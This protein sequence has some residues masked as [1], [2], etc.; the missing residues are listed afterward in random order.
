MTRSLVAIAFAAAVLPFAPL[1]AQEAKAY[2]TVY[3][4]MQT[5]FEGYYQTVQ[6]NVKFAEK[7]LEFFQSLKLRKDELKPLVLEA[8]KLEAK[9]KDDL[10]SPEAKKDAE[11]KL[12]IL[13]QRGGEKQQEYLR[14]RQEG[15]AGMDQQ[16]AK[17]EAALIDKLSDYVV[18][19][20]Q[21][22]GYDI[23]YDINGKSL[24]R[25]PI[26]LLYPK[27]LEITADL[28]E[29]VNVGHEEELKKAQEDLKAVEAR[30]AAAMEGEREGDAQ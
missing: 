21:G 4:N 26:L 13:M 8:K 14:F 11:M 3:V 19:F 2:K 27:E 25:M 22:N 29:A 15:R 17:A 24:N 12:R 5:V 20:C 23:V 6:E 9:L 7:K 1:H 10:V 18:K 16:R 28:A 30:L